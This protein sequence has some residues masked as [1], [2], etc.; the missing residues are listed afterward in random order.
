MATVLTPLLDLMNVFLLKSYSEITSFKQMIK[1][2]SNLNQLLK[3]EN[4]I[5][6]KIFSILKQLIFNIY[7]VLISQR[8]NKI[9]I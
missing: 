4:T 9:I 8:I 2:F 6:F 3:T 7:L 5:D 1:I